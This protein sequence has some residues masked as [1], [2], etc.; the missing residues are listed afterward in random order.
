MDY[1]TEQLETFQDAI[2]G[3]LLIRKR[4]GSKKGPTKEK[5][6]WFNFA[7]YTDSDTKG[8]IK[9]TWTH[10]TMDGR[11]LKRLNYFTSANDGQ[12]PIELLPNQERAVA[13]DRINAFLG[14]RSRTAKGRR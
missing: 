12:N 6:E 10:V 14:A 8:K 1:M 5:Q 4:S 7:E 2:A 13:H 11:T 9:Q 3:G